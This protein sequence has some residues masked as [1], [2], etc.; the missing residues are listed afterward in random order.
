MQATRTAPGQE[1]TLETEVLE[2]VPLAAEWEALAAFR[3]RPAL[4]GG[5]L[6]G[7]F[8]ALPVNQQVS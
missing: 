2:H 5:L 7:L 1:K 6:V 3:S 8:E 4:V